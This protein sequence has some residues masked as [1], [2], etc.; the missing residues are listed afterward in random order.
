MF[1]QKTFVAHRKTILTVTTVLLVLLSVTSAFSQPVDIDGRRELFVDRLLVDSMTNAEL[2]LH[3][4]IKTSRPK[5][6]LPEKH[7]FTILKDQ[8]EKG[9]LYRAYWRETDPMYPGP[10]HTGHAGEM[11][12]YAESRDGHEWTFP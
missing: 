8:D 4:P 10:F 6:P 5:S 9:D 11:V 2:R 3:H 7:Y 1:E 12:C